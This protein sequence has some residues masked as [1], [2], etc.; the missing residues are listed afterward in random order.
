MPDDLTTTWNRLARMHG[1]KAV[2]DLHITN[3]ALD[4]I[5]EDQ[6]AYLAPLLKSKLRGTEKFALDYG[7]GAGRFTYMVADAMP[8]GGGTIAYD[9]SGEMMGFMPYRVDRKD[10]LS[11]VGSQEFFFESAAFRHYQF[12]LVFI[13]CVLGGID[14]AALPEL[15]DNLASVMAP[16][17]LLF[18]CDH[19]EKR[20]ENTWWNFHPQEFYYRLFEPRGIKLLRSG[21]LWQLD[22][23]V[24]VMT[25]RK[26]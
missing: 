25:G 16:D 26:K 15:A 7:C 23:S 10:V 12:D 20:R 21:L 22:N 1:R 13:F 24:T 8:K 17:G 2:V 11:D 9:P 3:E 6:I 19:T 4:Q 18:L 14:P 5:T